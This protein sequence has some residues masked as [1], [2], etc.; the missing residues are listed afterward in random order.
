MQKMLNMLEVPAL[1]SVPCVLV[2]CVVFPF[3]QSGLVSMLAVCACIAVVFSAYEASR[4]PLRQIMP[5]VVLGALAAAGR[6]LFAPI[7]DFKPV[8]AI[9]MLAGAVFG[10]REG[11]LV[12]AL[13][14][15]VSNFFFGQGSWTPWQMYAWGLVGYFGGVFADHGLF[16]RRWF[17]YVCGF[18]SGLMYGAILNGYYVIGFVHPITWG[19]VALALA[20]ALPLDCTHGAA[21]VIFL[22][23]IY[24]P[25][26]HKLVRIRNKYALAEE[27]GGGRVQMES[28]AEA[29]PALG[30]EAGFAEPAAGAVKVCDAGDSKGEEL[31]LCTEPELPDDARVYAFLKVVRGKERL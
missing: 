23:A 18:A 4:P 20:A 22:R 8:S 7:P 24:V 11:F 21:T 25:W 15:L 16:Q 19:S 28:A 30:T 31:V 6:I 29:N 10:R 5:T 26:E 2:L 3:D 1:V 12:G 27:S 9:C 17:L 14:A 13:A